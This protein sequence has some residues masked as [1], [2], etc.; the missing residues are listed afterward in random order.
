MK[1]GDVKASEELAADGVY[2]F[3]FFCTPQRGQGA[4]AS[5]T[6]PAALGQPD[7]RGRP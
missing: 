4:T 2:V 3:V 5:S 1:F 7:F 6:A